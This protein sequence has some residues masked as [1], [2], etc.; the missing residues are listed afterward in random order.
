MSSK[1]RRSIK[2][3]GRQLFAPDCDPCYTYG[4]KDLTNDYDR[5]C[6]LEGWD[7]ALRE[8]EATKQK[9]DCEEDHES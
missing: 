9:L 8:Y 4:G 5:K 6:F 1:R 3:E 7:S 2:R